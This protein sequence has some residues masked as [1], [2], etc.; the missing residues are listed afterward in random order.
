MLVQRQCAWVLFSM[1]VSGCRVDLNPVPKNANP[2][3]KN[4]VETLNPVA[5]HMAWDADGNVRSIDLGGVR[6]SSHVIACVNQLDHVEE[7]G[8]SPSAFRDEHLEQLEPNKIRSLS[9]A[10]T[11][12]T[13]AGLKHLLRFEHLV[14]LDI[15]GT[16]VSDAGL[17]CLME[18]PHLEWLFIE[19]TQITAEGEERL[20]QNFPNAHI[21]REPGH[22]TRHGR[23]AESPST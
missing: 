8:L 13:D 21:Q 11:E 14:L 18:L 6:V 22:P 5:E 4:A 2:A 9:L 3:E 23:R 17:P 1:C 16:A 19:Q 10:W 15:H 12:V 7:L 20:R